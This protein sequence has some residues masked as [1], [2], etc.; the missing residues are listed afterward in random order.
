[1][2]ELSGFY[3]Q[4]LRDSG[5]LTSF[6]IQGLVMWQRTWEEGVAKAPTDRPW[7]V[8]RIGKAMPLGKGRTEVKTENGRQLGHPVP[9][10][11]FLLETHNIRTSSAPTPL[12]VGPFQSDPHPGILSFLI[13]KT[14][15]IKYF[16]ALLLPFLPSPIPY[17]LPLPPPLPS[18]FSSITLSSP[19][20]S[21]LLHPTCFLSSLLCTPCPLAP[22]GHSGFPGPT[23]DSGFRVRTLVLDPVS[24]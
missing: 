8:N 10:H 11:H 18:F 24:T 5:D 17:F 9:Q 12:K 19:F 15:K 14:G 1:M 22:L 3:V 20:S 16:S 13:D 6:L 23:E 4:H 2:R 7:T 21:P